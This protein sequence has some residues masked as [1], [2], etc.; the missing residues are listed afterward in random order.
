MNLDV[1]PGEANRRMAELINAYDTLSD[2]GFAD[3]TSGSRVV[4]A[5]F[6]KL[7]APLQFPSQLFDAAA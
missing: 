5:H 4:G 7:F 3:R 6:T 2:A 1:D